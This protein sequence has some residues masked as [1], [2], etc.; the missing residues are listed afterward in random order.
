MGDKCYYR[1]ILC[2][3]V[4]YMI[5]S[6]LQKG[7]VYENQDKSESDLQTLFIS[8]I[9]YQRFLSSFIATEAY[10]NTFYLHLH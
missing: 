9:H 3:N 1:I 7:S 2:S 4:F 6:S 5:Y 10:L 8:N